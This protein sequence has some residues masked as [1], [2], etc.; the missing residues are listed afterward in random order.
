MMTQQECD[1]LGFVPGS[2]RY[3]SLC[4]VPTAEVPEWGGG[5]G[6]EEFAPGKNFKSQTP[7]MPRAV[8]SHAKVPA[9]LSLWRGPARRLSCGE[10]MLKLTAGAQF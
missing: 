9:F 8:S 6:R 4:Y 1:R 3:Q 10:D 2:V 5:K 7:E